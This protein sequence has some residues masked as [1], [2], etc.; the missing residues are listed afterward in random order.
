MRIDGTAMYREFAV[1]PDL[2][3]FPN[4]VLS[5]WLKLKRPETDRLH[6]RLRPVTANESHPL[7]GSG[8]LDQRRPRAGQ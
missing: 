2:I 4:H 1:N 5:Q 7:W 3:V 8:L 6:F